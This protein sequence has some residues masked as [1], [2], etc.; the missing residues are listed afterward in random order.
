[1]VLDKMG[2]Y[3]EMLGIITFVSDQEGTL[4]DGE[5][6]RSFGLKFPVYDHTGKQFD[7]YVEIIVI[8]ND[9]E[10]VFSDERMD[11]G[12]QAW[13]AAAPWFARPRKGNSRNFIN[14]RF[15][16]LDIRLEATE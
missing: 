13:V 7:K 3:T 14:E 10:R 11:V 1:M 8:G 12:M 2:A 4:K 9:V 5:A 15:N 16:L 6:I